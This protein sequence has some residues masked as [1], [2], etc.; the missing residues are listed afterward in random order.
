M[1][2]EGK[3]VKHV[4]IGIIKHVINTSLLR[5]LHVIIEV[6]DSALLAVLLVPLLALLLALFL[7]ASHCIPNIINTSCNS[8]HINALR[9]VIT[10][11]LIK[12]SYGFN[13]YLFL[14]SC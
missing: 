14:L 7:I 12:F 6:I 10:L 3:G 11:H 9:C 8:I 4:I 2:L 13:C 1:G 5:L